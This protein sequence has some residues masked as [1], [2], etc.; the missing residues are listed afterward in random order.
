MKDQLCKA[1]CDN[2]QV[3]RVPAGL[4]VSTSFLSPE[5]DRIGFYVRDREQ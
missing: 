5:G 2:V 1:F 3:R 4:A